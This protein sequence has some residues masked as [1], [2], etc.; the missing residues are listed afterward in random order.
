MKKVLLTLSIIG[1]CFAANAQQTKK[2]VQKPTT[3]TAPTTTAPTTTTANPNGPTFK[4][5]KEVFDF[6]TVKQ[7]EVVTYEFS[8]TNAGKEPL[9]ITNATAT[10]GCTVPH[11]PKEPIKPGDKGT[12]KVSFNTAGKSGMQDKAVTITSNAREG[13]KVIHVKG[14]IEVKPVEETFPTKKTTEGAP[15]EKQN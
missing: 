10:C 7:G 1:V 14:T 8:F 3:T 5:E 12:I 2:D 6:G 13:N 15:V 4:F 9:I 11:F